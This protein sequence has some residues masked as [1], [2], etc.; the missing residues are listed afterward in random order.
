MIR[1]RHEL[2]MVKVRVNVLVRLSTMN[3][4]NRVS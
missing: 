2:V 1:V 3:E 4:V